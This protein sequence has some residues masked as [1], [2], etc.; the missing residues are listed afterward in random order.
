MAV[1]FQEKIYSLKW[2]T[3]ENQV[4][5]LSHLAY[6]MQAREV[7][8]IGAFSLEGLE[9]GNNTTKTLENTR[10][11]EG[12]QAVDPNA[13]IQRITNRAWSKTCS[14]QQYYR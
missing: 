14:W 11:L 12:Q 1:E 2:V 10:V 9:H 13:Q 4:H 7:K 8:S 6:F 3:P 5:R